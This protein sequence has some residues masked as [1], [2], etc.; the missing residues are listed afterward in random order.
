MEN[1]AIKELTDYFYSEL[2]NKFGD[3]IRLNGHS[4]R[5]LPNT[6]NVSFLGYNGHKILEH[7][8]GTAASTGSACHSGTTS[9]SPVLKAMGVSDEVGR[10]AVR[11][12]LGR[13]TTKNEIDNVIEELK[14]LKQSN[15]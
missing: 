4:G 6:L 2:K 1:P 9:I 13:Y 14:K 5:K 3:R 8:N 15:I 7:L 12:S 10:G 11:F